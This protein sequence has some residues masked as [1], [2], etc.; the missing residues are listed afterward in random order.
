MRVAP[1]A[2]DAQGRTKTTVLCETVEIVD[3]KYRPESLRNAPRL[4]DALRSS[5][6]LSVCRDALIHVE[7]IS[8]T[9]H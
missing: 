7:A 3:N 8:F 4:A 9:E 1:Q 6:M 2:P 5:R